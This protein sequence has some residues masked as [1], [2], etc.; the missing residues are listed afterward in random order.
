MKEVP[1]TRL[2]KIL[3]QFALPHPVSIV[4]PLGS[5]HINDS[6]LVS[7]GI[8]EESGYVLQRINHI[9]FKDINGLTNNILIVTRHIEQ[10][11]RK[12]P[13]RFGHFKPL[14][15]ILTKDE[16][17]FS[18]DEEGNF[19][20]LFNYISPCHSYDLVTD[21]DIAYEGGKGFGNF[22]LL[23][24]GIDASTLIET[25]PNFHDIAFRLDLFNQSI[26]R[27]NAGRVSEVSP[28]I[29]F[30]MERKDEMYRIRQL[31]EEK[32][33]PLRVTHN[34]TKL[35]NILFD[36]NNKAICIVDLDTVM[37]G[38]ILYD[39]GDAI[40]T[41]AN[42]CNEDEKNTTR[43]ALNLELFEAYSKGYLNVVKEIITPC[44]K[45]NFAFSARFMTFIIGLRFLTDFLDGDIYYKIAF[46]DHNLRR[47]R[48]QF[49]LMKDME[50]NYDKM[51]KIIEHC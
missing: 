12:Q 20:R 29:D 3:R 25:I 13:G 23:T 14:R 15:V 8:P 10:E 26:Q 46:P 37:P 33:I 2:K 7:T 1:V 35:N 21:P 18:R 30:V 43:V 38:Y 45:E 27:D 39:Y 40:R 47:A 48:V 19:W 32:K 36:E 31:A 50:K 28:E 24:S 6:Y 4:S 51:R 9:I 11:I 44:E 34:D 5:G 41:G 42:T 49:A 17:P 16:K 22:M